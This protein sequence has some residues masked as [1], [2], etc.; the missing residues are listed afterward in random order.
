MDQREVFILALYV[1][2]PKSKDSRRPP[3]KEMTE[4]WLRTEKHLDIREY[5]EG[6]GGVEAGNMAIAGIYLLCQ[7]SSPRADNARSMRTSKLRRNR[8]A[9]RSLKFQRYT[10]FHCRVSS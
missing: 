2:K 10:S 6:E 4:R 3:S 9:R 1:P 8:K 7:C 5:I